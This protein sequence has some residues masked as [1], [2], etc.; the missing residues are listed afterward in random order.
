[1]PIKP[2]KKVAK[3]KSTF[4]TAEGLYDFGKMAKQFKGELGADNLFTHLKQPGPT[5]IFEPG[6]LKTFNVTP[7]WK[8]REALYTQLQQIQ[9]QQPM[10]AL[11]S[12][13]GKGASRKVKQGKKEDLLVQIE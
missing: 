3:R 4:L 11:R 6:A 12:K 9:Q 2:G 8:L 5:I 10:S 13:R 7:Y 1:M